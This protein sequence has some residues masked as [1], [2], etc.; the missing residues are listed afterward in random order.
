MVREPETPV[1]ILWTLK[2]M[3]H[4]CQRCLSKVRRVEGSNI[5]VG[6][7]HLFLKSPCSQASLSILPASLHLSPSASVPPVSSTSGHPHPAQ[8]HWPSPLPRPTLPSF[9][10]SL[11]DCSNRQHR[12]PGHLSLNPH[13]FPA[14][15]LCL[16]PHPTQICPHAVPLP[17]SCSKPS[18]LSRITGTTSQLASP[19]PVLPPCL[20]PV[21]T[22]QHSAASYFC[23]HHLAGAMHST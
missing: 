21:P 12:P 8:G 15:S 3:A 5:P 1:S 11:L 4:W 20:S 23:L 19:L 6:H 14:S 17:P 22:T 18:L 13:F 2:R 10:P 9:T 7:P 16:H